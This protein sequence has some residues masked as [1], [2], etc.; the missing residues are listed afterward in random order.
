MAITCYLCGIETPNNKRRKKLHGTSCSEARKVLEQLC[1][2]PLSVIPEIK[3][4]GCV[5]CS[6]CESSIVPGCR[7]FPVST[8]SLIK[9]PIN[10]E[11]IKSIYQ[12]TIDSAFNFNFVQSANSFNNL[13]QSTT[14]FDSANN[15]LN[16]TTQSATSLNSANK[17]K[18]SIPV[19]AALSV[20]AFCLF[21][22]FS[23][24]ETHS[25]PSQ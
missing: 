9:S 17:L 16:L 8:P 14:S 15:P 4:D 3:S 12:S 6:K 23:I 24:A 20:I 10:L 7:I 18:L 11:F 5:L 25:Q 22:N 2:L 21:K 19:L 13:T 1:T